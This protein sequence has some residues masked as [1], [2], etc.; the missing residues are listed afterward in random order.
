MLLQKT[1]CD[2]DVRWLSI[3]EEMF[4]GTMCFYRE[5]RFTGMESVSRGPT[6]LEIRCLSLSG[7]NI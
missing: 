4:R 2:L 7:K 1:V 3:E 6:Y 5:H